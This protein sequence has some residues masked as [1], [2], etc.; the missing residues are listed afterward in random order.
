MIALAGMLL[1]SCTGKRET[2]PDLLLRYGDKELTYSEVVDM[3]PQGLVPADS[4]ALFNAIVEGW[5][6]TEVLADF[7]QERLYDMQEIERKVSDYRNALIVEEY[8]KKMRS[9]TPPQIEDSKIKDYYDRHRKD[10]KLE[11]PLVKGI[12]LKINSDS[13]RK[14]EI[15]GLL[16][17][18]DPAK[19]DKLEQ[20]WLDRAL[21]YN[22]FRDKWVDWNT[23]EKIIPYRFGNPE[24]FLKENSYL[25]TTY[26]DCTYYLRVTDYIESGEEQPYE[27]AKT[28]IR[29]VLTQGELA[30][31]QR[32]LVN[33]IVNKA[34]KESKLEVYGYDPVSH[35]VTL[36]RE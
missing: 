22:Y 2:A 31:N 8:L 19:T 36:K 7:A 9:S 32:Q 20:N 14:E 21:E 27:F 11:I 35:Q 13:P 16:E 10:L 33:S 28:W 1:V 5:L 15:R 24:E 12:F 6:S 29:D 34:I 17:S 26:G 23:I 3:I 25:E 18:D 4:A 30:E